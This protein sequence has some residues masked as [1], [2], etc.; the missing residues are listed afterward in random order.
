MNRNLRRKP[1]FGDLTFSDYREHP[2]YRGVLGHWLIGEGGGVTVRDISGHGHHG[3]LTNMDPATD[4]VMGLQGPELDFDA[5]N[6]HVDFGGNDT[7]VLGS[8]DWSMNAWVNL[9]ANGNYRTIFSNSGSGGNS[10][11]LLT[12]AS[13]A[14][15]FINDAGQLLILGSVMV[16]G[17]LI[18]LTATKQGSTCSVYID[19]KFIASG[20]RD[21]DFNF[22]MIGG[23]IDAS[24]MFDGQISAVRI[25]NRVLTLPE[26]QSLFTDPFLEFAPRRVVVQVSGLDLV[27]VVDETENLSEGVL[28]LGAL[29]RIVNETEN[30]SEGLVQAMTLL[31]LVNE[32]E[33]ISDGLI[34]VLAVLV[35][36]NETENIT[37]ATVIVKGVNVLVNETIEVAEAIEAILGKLVV[38]NETVEIS[39]GL[40]NVIG[41]VQVITE[42][43][44]VSEGLLQTLTLLRLHNE[45]INTTEGLVTTEAIT[46]VINETLQVQENLLLALVLLQVVVET[47][48]LTESTSLNLALVRMLN[49]MVSVVEALETLIG[50]I[51]VID[52]GVDVSENV[53]KLLSVAA[54]FLCGSVQVL[55]ELSGNASVKSELSGLVK[56]VGQLLAEI[57]VS[58]C[59]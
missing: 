35:V 1:T 18:N 8:N 39:E 52:E 41:I 58:K 32:S 56:T 51:V 59:P 38:Q 55:A 17:R 21:G 36:L 5:D 9:K 48:N 47:V 50:L 42:T 19:G 23:R 11:A 45:T 7:I 25:Y 26:I 49:E 37:E 30:I 54:D 20:T 6:D 22:G 57:K 31:Q 3:T 40:L 29:F 12:D 53:A 10:T 43:V 46:Q 27:K 2:R 16:T 14:F 24:Q 28:T 13:A 33:Q 4:W 34:R 44:N 15:W